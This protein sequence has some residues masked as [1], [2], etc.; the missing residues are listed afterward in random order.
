MALMSNP[1][2]QLLG[3]PQAHGQLHPHE[4]HQSLGLL[5]AALGHG[6]GQH[7]QPHP[8]P[9][10]HPDRGGIMTP[11]APHERAHGD[12]ADFGQRQEGDLAGFEHGILPPGFGH[13]PHPPPISPAMP[14][15]GIHWF[16]PGGSGVSYPAVGQGGDL[17]GSRGIAYSE[18]IRKRP[19]LSQAFQAA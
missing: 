16:G 7:F 15:Q 17:R 5:L 3:G 14:P 8:G 18:P 1:I 2:W 11:G 6:G 13:Q 19:A 4:Q 9:L 10:G 12:L